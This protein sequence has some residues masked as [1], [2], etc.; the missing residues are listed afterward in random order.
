[1]DE[2]PLLKL[3]YIL[4]AQS[5]KHVTHNE[6]LRALDAL[7]QLSV[8]DKDLATPP[9]SPSASACYIVGAAPTGLWS[10]HATHIAAYQDEA[11]AFYVPLEG[12]LAWVADE[13]VLYAFDGAAG[14]L[15]GCGRA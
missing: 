15:A 14:S 1:M 5:Q 11:W 13:N 8:L 4:A 3:P 6:A 12:W 10:G 2:T 7:V 9:G